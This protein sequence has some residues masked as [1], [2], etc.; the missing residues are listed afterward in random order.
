[1]ILN[2]VKMFTILLIYLAGPRELISF[3]SAQG[4]PEPNIDAANQSN[5]VG[6]ESLI[7]I[8]ARPDNSNQI[9]V[10]KS[11]NWCEPGVDDR[12]SDLCAQWKSADASA[13]SAFWGIMSF[14]L[15]AAGTV[16]LLFT[17]YY[18]RQS[19]IAAQSAANAALESSKDSEKA[20]AIAARNSEI[21]AEANKILRESDRA[22]VVHSGFKT[23]HIS[24]SIIDGKFIQHALAFALIWSNCGKNPAIKSKAYSRHE[25]LKKGESAPLFAKNK[26][27]IEENFAASVGPGQSVE[28][29]PCIL[30]KAEF[31]KLF[32]GEID[33]YV[34]GVVNYSDAHG[35]TDLETEVCFK[36][37]CNGF[38]PSN[39][40]QLPHFSFLPMGPQNRMK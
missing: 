12:R 14:W 9:D 33:V 38:T 15:T 40:G 6:S 27:G 3:A 26:S 8:I 37:I 2:A 36:L 5:I 7:G 28:S 18:T 10:K 17:L 23:F 21:A 30:E 25:V 22:W 11:E 32:R 39:E 4:L 19:A 24:D 29:Q 13:I 34:Y 1:M 20:L 31:D 16:G 35:L